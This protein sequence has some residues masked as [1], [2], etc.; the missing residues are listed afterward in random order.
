MLVHTPPLREHRGKL[1][2]CRPAFGETSRKFNQR[3]SG[4]ARAGCE[5]VGEGGDLSQLAVEALVAGV[6]LV[7][8]RLLVSETLA[9]PAVQYPRTDG[10]G[11]AAR[12]Q[13]REQNPA[14]TLLIDRG[15]LG[16]ELTELRQRFARPGPQVQLEVLG[17][18]TGQPQDR[19]TGG[20]SVLRPLIDGFGTEPAQPQLVEVEETRTRRAE[21]PA[22]GR[23]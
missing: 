7:G 16:R 8:Q 15:R 10:E 1:L 6:D 23:L 3:P 18:W 17:H 4:L 2:G 20:E 12:A 13:H 22:P 11:A 19:V 21:T 5:R 9:K 14:V